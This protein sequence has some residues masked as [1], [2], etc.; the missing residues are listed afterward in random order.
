MIDK[1]HVTCPKC[2]SSAGWIQ[3]GRVYGW[4]FELRLGEL[5]TCTCKNCGFT[6]VLSEKNDCENCLYFD[7]C[8]THAAMDINLCA[9]KWKFDVLMVSDL[10]MMLDE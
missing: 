1:R 7:L 2:L 3:M 8:T 6:W 5:Y 4:A 10:E 9:L